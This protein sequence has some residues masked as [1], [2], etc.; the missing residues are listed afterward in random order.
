MNVVFV[1]LDRC[2]ACLSCQRACQ[3]QQA[4]RN[5]GWAPN[6]FIHVDM[7]RRIIYTGTCL[8]CETAPCMDVCP[9]SALTRDPVT[10]AVIVDKKTCLGCGLCVA[11]CPF[12]YMQLDEPLR[13]ATKCDL[14]GGDPRCVQ[15][16][17]ARALHFGSI[18]SLAELKRKHTDLRLGLRAISD[19]EDDNR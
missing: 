12:G 8:Q 10:A 17:M 19:D 16:C 1:E 11:A 7:D 5:S 13:I 2:I 9:V 4:D 18:N 15:M 14:C 6:I 3:F